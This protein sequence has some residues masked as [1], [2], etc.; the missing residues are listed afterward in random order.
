[1]TQLWDGI[2]GQ[3]SAKQSLEKFLLSKNIPQAIIFNGLDGIGKDF[4]AARFARILNNMHDDRQDFFTSSVLKYIIPLPT[5]K[6]EISSDGPLDKFSNSEY[7]FII[8]E[9]EK[10]NENPYYSIN[11]PKANVIKLNSIREIN[12]YLALSFSEIKYRIILISAAHYMN[13]EAQNAL[14]KNL[15]E[16]PPGVIFILTTSNL[17]ELKETIRSRCWIVDFEPL[18]EEDILEILSRYF[19]VELLLAK[20]V[21][22]VAMGSI[23]TAINYVQNDL[24]YLKD[25]VIIFLRNALG[26]KFHTAV[27]ELSLISKENSEVVVEI[28]LKL[29][30]YWLSDV[31]KHRNNSNE[32][33][34]AGHIETLEKFN[35]KY[36]TFDVKAAM[37]S[38]ENMLYL[39]S[40]TNVNLNIIWFTLIFEINSIRNLHIKEDLF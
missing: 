6:N 32:L 26:G 14:L 30:L 20:E 10:K 3:N 12:K 39:Y 24:E 35:A 33:F 13:E 17:I 1:M 37:S 2:L 11:I 16:P 15:E 27:K 23:T 9:I 8:S 34:F 40:N 19:N 25:K 36:S 4:I 29:I 21:K 28:F 7:E 31:E 22:K 5:G 18:S 38:I